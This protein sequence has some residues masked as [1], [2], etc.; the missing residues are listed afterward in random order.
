MAVTT[1]H[2][3]IRLAS[4]GVSALLWSAAVLG[5]GV[6][7][8][9][10]AE[11][12]ALPP[13]EP[14]AIDVVTLPPP[15][16]PP[17]QATATVV[18]RFVEAVL[19][20]VPVAPP[21]PPAPAP[22]PAVVALAPALAPAPPVV[23]RPDWVRRPQNLGRYYPERAHARGKTGQVSLDCLVRRDGTLACAVAEETPAGWGFADAALRMSRAYQMVPATRDGQPV[24]AR[25]TLR[26][27][28]T[29][30]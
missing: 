10:V 8:V 6:L 14:E 30:E 12:P 1:L 13:A 11:P 4:F 3:G 21:A 9:K 16:A 5:L 23:T 25:Y 17:I 19:P 15:P 27:P 7:G 22:G 28:F 29:L 18:E 26:V 24:E 20:V 2:P